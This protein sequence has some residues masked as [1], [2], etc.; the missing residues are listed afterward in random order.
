MQTLWTRKGFGAEFRWQHRKRK[1]RYML[2][3]LFMSAE[4]P[5]KIRISGR[6]NRQSAGNPPIGGA[7]QRLHAR[8]P[9][10]RDDDIVQLN[11]MNENI[12]AIL[13]GLALG[14]GYLT[15]FVG[16][17]CRSRTEIKGDNKNLSYLKWLHSQLKPLGCSDLKPKKNYH[18][19]RF[20][21]KTTEEIGKLRELFY[22]KGKKIVPKNIK[23]LLRNP[24]TLA[25]WYQDDGTLDCRSK[26]HYNAMFATYCFSFSDCKL[27]AKALRENFN[28]DARVCK[29]KMRGKTRYRLYIASK[30]M[31]NFVGLVEPHIIT[32]FRYKIR[33]FN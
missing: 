4:F 20:Y 14:D 7:P 1:S 16:K 8:L 13:I 15:P 32:C 18:Q 27:L 25:V 23:E 19:H 26:Y 6:L 12:K 30:S 21:T 31:N 10:L 2:E 11:R 22:P 24:L 29:C 33:K 28:L 5:D 3:T 17:S 9:R